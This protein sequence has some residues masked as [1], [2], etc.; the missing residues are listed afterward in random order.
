MLERL[1]AKTTSSKFHLFVKTVEKSLTLYTSV[2][3]TLMWKGTNKNGVAVASLKSL[4]AEFTVSLEEF[5]FANKTSTSA[6]IKMEF[7]NM[8]GYFDA[9][10]QAYMC[11]LIEVFPKRRTI[12]HYPPTIM[13]RDF[14]KNKFRY[15]LKPRS[16]WDDVYEDEA[17]NNSLS[18]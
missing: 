1:S 13:F 14:D 12:D 2:G 18:Q 4:W 3:Y 10:D 8:E 6:A 9:I 11:D 16:E 7:Y 5:P 17:L 15:I